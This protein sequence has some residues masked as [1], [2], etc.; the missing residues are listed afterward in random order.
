MQ[1]D[2]VAAIDRLEGE[3]VL[4]PPT[5]ASLRRVAKGDLVSIRF[6]LRA[7]L[8]SGVALIASG[9]GFFVKEHYRQIGP[10]AITLVLSLACAAC[11]AYVLGRAPGFSWL[12]TPSPTLAFDYIL[13]LAALLFGIDLAYVEAQFKL[14]GPNWEYH[15]LIYSVLCLLLA[16]RFDSSAVLS[17][18]LTSFAAWRGVA[19]KNTLV[20]IFGDPSS[21]V[22]AN[23][24]FCGALFAAGAIVSVRWRRKAHFEAIWA[25]LGLLLLFGSLLSGALGDSNWR[26]WEA[27]LLLL[28][29][30]AVAVGLRFRRELYLAEG[31]IAGYV[32]ALRAVLD[33]L[34]G[35]VAPLAVV[36]TSA[37][38]VLVL[39]LVLHRIVGKRRA[40]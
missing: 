35:E 33:G 27:P 1:P 3:N 15:L 20:S 12:R 18:A 21:R 25:N 28:S 13:L 16:Y 24:L 37:I 23:A 6:E 39:L 36:T 9:I 40:A 32:G 7:L 26:I 8:Y 14:L 5:A 29:A 19:A 2:I 17:L 22:R 31:V 10:V 38:G 4:P 11:L 34:H 30:A